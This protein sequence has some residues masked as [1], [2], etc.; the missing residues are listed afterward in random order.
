MARDDDFEPRLG[1]IRNAGAGRSRRYLHQV[2]QAVSQAG[3]THSKSR[4]RF[5]G[6][7]IG[8]GCGV[9]RVLASRDRYAAYRSRRVVVKTRIVKLQGKGLAGAQRHLRYL[10]RDG[11][12]REGE[13]GALY[14]AGSDRADGKAF[15]QRGTGD[16]H[17]FRVIV[18]AEDS[19]EYDD[20]KGFTR[21]L[22]R[23][24]E[25]DLGTKLDWVAVDHHNTGHPHTHIVVR[26]KDARDKDLIIARDYV[27]YGM[28]ERAA[29][30]VAFDLGPKSD[31]AI[32]IQLKR[33]VEQERLT[34]IDRTLLRQAG[35]ERWVL[36]VGRPDDAISQTL[37]AGRLQKLRRLGLADEWRPGIWQLAEDMEPT[38]R[39]MGERGD[40]IKT[41]HR[42]MAAEDP[43]VHDYAIFDGKSPVIGRMVMRGL[44]DELND[45]HYLVID[46]VDGRSHYAD[47]G[48]PKS[49]DPLPA[50]AIVRLSARTVEP[51]AVDHTV[52]EIAAAHGGHYSIH[53]HAQHDPAASRA[54][55]ETH[56]RRLEAMRR[57]GVDVSR[58]MDGTWTV[59]AD[60]V[61]RAAAYEQSQARTTPMK[62]EILSTLGLPQQ[63]S[64]DGPTWLDRQLIADTAPRAAGFGQDV[65]AALARRRQWLIA[66]GFAESDGNQIRYSR[67]MLAD[68]QK[69]ELARVGAQ[70]SGE[71]G[72]RF[73]EAPA[74]GQIAGIYRKSI[75]LVGGRFAV[76]AK[77]REFSLVPWRP[78]LEN[79][80]GKSVT[81]FI[82]GSGVSWTIGRSR[83][84]PS[85]S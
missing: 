76:I 15:L 21:R 82:R 81:G 27:S 11:V 84:G 45:R 42:A 70:L 48:A 39:R 57:A 83:G 35:E 40:I 24:M 9:G 52:A 16:R 37:R 61:A 29:E 28:R 54:F 38:L 63:V 72:L 64:A 19:E 7:H 20:L 75:E 59:A 77:S 22:M 66:E 23:Q 1:K 41:L 46:G 74:K 33:E 25:S 65:N 8:R 62:V 10:Q 34:S 69:R 51:R 26:G 44:S 2:L 47:I 56:V 3:G 12:T 68:L 78:A 4:A 79:Q 31:A 55:V 85:V 67:T 32:E 53:L 71:L 13:A 49:D 30:I 60:H 36:A 43:G 5:Q 17:Q 80:I 73:T 58:D 50:G 18:S 6:N 14:D